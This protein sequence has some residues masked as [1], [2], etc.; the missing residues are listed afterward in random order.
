MSLGWVPDVEYADL[1]VALAR[2]YLADAGVRFDYLPGGPNAPQPVLEISAGEADFGDSDWLPYCDAIAQ[3]NDFVIVASLFPVAPVGL[4]SLP[5]HPVRTPADLPGKRFLVQGPN[6]RAMLQAL[7][8]INGLAEHYSTVPVG[9]SVEPLLEGAGDAYFCFI[10][11][12]PQSLARMG[13]RE[14]KDFY[15]TRLYDLGY[16]VSNSLL[17]I[18]R[19]TLRRRRGEMV[20]FLAALL[21][22][23]AANAADPAYGARL[24]VDRYGADLGLDLQQQI[25][26]NRLQ[27][28]L[29]TQPGAEIPFWFSEE[30][31]AGSMYSIARSS[32]RPSLPPPA[33]L[34][35]MSLL[36]EAFRAIR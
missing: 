18:E 32:G 29:E 23:H 5:A 6:E 28:P 11:N 12:Q 26:L 20:R 30:S 19:G 1:W 4:I 2:H 3:G 31:F 9:F 36:E 16:R 25:T 24:A 10:T 22:G 35:D 14:G 17:A 34:R 27:I 21:R 7:F 8:R 13:L 15:V 33:R